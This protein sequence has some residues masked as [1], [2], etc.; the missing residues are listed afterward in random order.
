MFE[1]SNNMANV[2]KKLYFIRHE[3]SCAN[4]LEKVCG[5][6]FKYKL[7]IR[8]KLM[9]RGF[10][11]NKRGQY[12]PD[13]HL[14]YFGVQHGLYLNKNYFS[15]A[16]SVCHNVEDFFCSQLVR[17]A[18]T[19]LVLFSHLSNINL[20]IIPF[21][22]E[23][24]RVIKGLPPGLNKDNQPT[25]IHDYSMKLKVFL[26]EF[27]KNEHIN[28]QMVNLRFYDSEYNLKHHK[29][30]NDDINWK[31]IDGNFIF[32]TEPHLGTFKM[33]FPGLSQNVKAI[34]PK[35]NRTVI[36]THSKFLES[37][38]DNYSQQVFNKNNGE[39]L[40]YNMTADTNGKA[41]FLNGHMYEY[42]SNFL[43]RRKVFNIV[44][45]TIP[46]I[47]IRRP[48]VYFDIRKK[49]ILQQLKDKKLK[50]KKYSNISSIGSTYCDLDDRRASY[51]FKI[52][53]HCDSDKKSLMSRL[54]PVEFNKS[55]AANKM[56][57]K[58]PYGNYQVNQVNLGGS[59]KP[60]KKPLSKKKKSISKRKP[61]VYTGKRGGQYIIKNKRKVY[62]SST[63][64]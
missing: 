57:H 5:K 64:R 27:R 53:E 39:T 59:K 34:N 26:K 25:N 31:I 42:D 18:E 21:I 63:Q 52:K 56:K 24:R 28:L 47:T 40:L 54:I 17:T 46:D 9:G 55:R 38:D 33:L 50:D 7:G 10:Y 44:R 35:I 45:F 11:Q 4:Q 60:K 30:I 37:I 6:D 41:K 12:A 20:H 36:I 58:V 14:S 1:Y 16:N 2:P 51:A 13:P 19:A 43:F 61:K 32:E 29:L 49:D 15:Q 48:N 3:H 22:S 8:G 23:K 62:L